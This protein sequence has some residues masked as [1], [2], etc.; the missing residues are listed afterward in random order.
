MI[1]A[2][3]AIAA[4]SIIFGMTLAASA[5]TEREA[6]AILSKVSDSYRTAQSYHF[7]ADDVIETK[8]E[9]LQMKREAHFVMAV[10][11]PDKFRMEVKGS[12]MGLD[13]VVVSSGT[14]TWEYLPRQKQYT[15]S[16]GTLT[17]VTSKGIDGS[18]ITSDKD[19]LMRV[20]AVALGVAIPN[21]QEI[22]N[23][24]KD[25][26]LLRE[27]AIELGGSSIDCYVVEADNAFPEFVERAN[28]S[29]KTFWIDKT[30]YVV[31]RESY[32]MKMREGPVGGPMETKHTTSFKLV[33]INEPIPDSLFVFAPP[34]DA[35]QV[36]DFDSLK[37]TSGA[38]EK[39]KSRRTN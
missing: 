24:V 21:Y 14:T 3:I 19:T 38:S 4:S 25:P 11:K 29:P 17:T 7:E 12:M 18:E 8:G 16:E 34:E 20:S 2:K 22:M 39:R 36:D 32:T 30:R 35:K 10:V 27:E 5:Q 9:G 6:R 26:R 31:L 28:T 37:D 23:I 13:I 1:K 33:K 15:R